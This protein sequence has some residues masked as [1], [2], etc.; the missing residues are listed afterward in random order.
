MIKEVGGMQP[1]QYQPFQGNPPSMPFMMRPPHSAAQNQSHFTGQNHFLSSLDLTNI[2]LIAKEYLAN[3]RGDLKKKWHIKVDSIFLNDLKRFKEKVDEKWDSYCDSDIK[4]LKS[5]KKTE[6]SVNKIF[7]ERIKAIES[8]RDS[9]LSILEDV[10]QR[11]AQNRREKLEYGVNKVYEYCCFHTFYVWGKSNI[12]VEVEKFILGAEMVL[13]NYAIKDKRQELHSLHKMVQWEID[14]TLEKVKQAKKREERNVDR[15]MNK[16]RLFVD[17]NKKELKEGNLYRSLQLGKLRANGGSISD[18]IRNSEVFTQQRQ[19][20]NQQQGFN[21][22]RSK[23]FYSKPVNRRQQ[24]FNQQPSNVGFKSF[25][26]PVK[27]QQPVRQQQRFNQQQSNSFYLP[28][29]QQGNQNPQLKGV[30]QQQ[31]NSFY[32]N[33]A[34]IKQNLQV[35]RN[36]KLEERAKKLGFQPL[37]VYRDANQKGHIGVKKVF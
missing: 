16:F 2:E 9:I 22:R 4:S 19:R 1:H 35:H 29:R 11:G 8:T 31:S 37:H 26:T 25:S 17:E 15:I 18:Q 27:P 21:Q 32:S 34:P 24:G 3:P 5:L 30:N 14:S 23:T 7:G 12:F 6:D 13:N 28:Q 36:S 20:D 10:K 33:Q